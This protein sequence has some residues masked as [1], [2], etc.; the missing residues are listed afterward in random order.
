M[1]LIDLMDFSTQILP[2]PPP[3]PL[4]LGLKESVPKGKRAH[5]TSSQKSMYY[6]HITPNGLILGLQ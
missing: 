3:P 6:V 5:F 4:A 2:P 1:E